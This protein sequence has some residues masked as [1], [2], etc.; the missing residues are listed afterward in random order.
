MGIKIVYCIFH[1]I[2]RHNISL[3]HILNSKIK[4]RL[5]YWLSLNKLSNPSHFFERVFRKL[6]S[7]TGNSM[8]TVFISCDIAAFIF[9]TFLFLLCANFGSHIENSAYQPLKWLVHVSDFLCAKLQTFSIFSKKKILFLV[10]PYNIC[11]RSSFA[12]PSF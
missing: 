9:F 6:Y 4:F 2:K 8:L 11:L 5:R 7:D 1:I 3:L 10:F 12:M